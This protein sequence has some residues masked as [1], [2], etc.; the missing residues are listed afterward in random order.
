[1]HDVDFFTTVAK[2]DQLPDSAA[3]VAFVG[4]SNCGK[5]SFINALTNRRIAYISK[6]PGRTQHIN[7]FKLGNTTQFLVDLPGY[8]YAKVPLSVKDK[9]GDI[10]SKYLTTRQSLKGIVLLMDCRHPMK[11]LDQQ[12]LKLWCP[13]N[14]PLLILLSKV[15]KISRDALCKQIAQLEKHHYDL[16]IDHTIIGVSVLKNIG[17]QTASQK[18]HSWLQ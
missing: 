9:W 14:K 6:T 16:G 11:P 12:L 10:L 18:I 4:S 17:V 13:L 15:D 5:S 2:L 3:E 7:F 1:M 8:G